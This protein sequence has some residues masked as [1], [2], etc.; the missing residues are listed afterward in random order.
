MER[1][2]TQLTAFASHLL[3]LTVVYEVFARYVFGKSNAGIS[4]TEVYAFSVLILFG[5]YVAL[6]K[7]G[8]VNIDLVYGKMTEKN[9]KIINVF[10]IVFFLIP[11]CLTALYTSFDFMLVSFALNEKSTDP[12]GFEFRFLLKSI[13]PAAFL[14]MIIGAL[15]KLIRALK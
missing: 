4:D 12:G 9:R 7:N 13:I 10:A 15:L 14:L 11:F 5:A 1:F 8:H 3:V 6:Q 2:F